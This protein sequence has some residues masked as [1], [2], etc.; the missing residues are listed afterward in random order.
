MSIEAMVALGVA[1]GTF[2]TACI[3]F[4]VYVG[5]L[6][7]RVDTVERDVNACFRMIRERK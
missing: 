2:I 6:Q 3:S 1:G 4:G 7:S 5:K